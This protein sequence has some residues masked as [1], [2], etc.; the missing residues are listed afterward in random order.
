MHILKVTKSYNLP[1]LGE[2]LVAQVPTFLRTQERD[3]I[4]RTLDDSGVVLGGDG[5]V[6]IHFADDISESIVKR[7]VTAHDSTMLSI[8]QQK[9]VERE[10]EVARQVS[11]N[12]KLTDDSITFDE[13]K[14]LMRLRG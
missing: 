12:V 5:Y 6:E 4:S 13:L 3:G 7:V 9:A 14:E 2:E 1:L 8:N 11:L 10:K